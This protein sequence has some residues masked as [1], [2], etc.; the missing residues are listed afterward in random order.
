MEKSKATA[1]QLRDLAGR[2][3]DMTVGEAGAACALASSVSGIGVCI[4]GS[5]LI[6]GVIRHLLDSADICEAAEMRRAEAAN[7]VAA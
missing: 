5:S 7:E 4:R 2:V 1:A 6:A 3:S